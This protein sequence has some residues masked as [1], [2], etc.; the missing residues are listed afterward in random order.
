MSR[1]RQL[2]SE[3]H[4]RS[5]WQVLGIYIVAP[6]LMYQLVQSPTQGLGLP[7]WFPALAVVLLL[8]GLPIV[9]ATTF[10]Q[11]ALGGGPDDALPGLG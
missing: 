3:A 9:L 4:R 7:D 1:L 8:V 6:R 5:P 2:I 10:V 11:E